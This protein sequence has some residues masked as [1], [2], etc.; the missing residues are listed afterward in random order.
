MIR[1]GAKPSLGTW[2]KWLGLGG[3]LLTPQRNN[4]I[5]TLGPSQPKVNLILAME[6]LENSWSINT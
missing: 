6:S 2:P 5:S 3:F 1:L 4:F